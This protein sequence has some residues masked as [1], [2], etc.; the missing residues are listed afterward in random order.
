MFDEVSRRTADSLPL[1]RPKN[2]VDWPEARFLAVMFV[3]D[4]SRT[5]MHRC[6]AAGLSAPC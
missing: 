5:L 3:R 2:Q 1:A 6:F 4:V